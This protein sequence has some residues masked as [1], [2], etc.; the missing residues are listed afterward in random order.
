MDE[1][2][3]TTAASS[4]E[5]A[6]R[7]E[8]QARRSAQG[9]LWTWTDAIVISCPQ[10][11]PP[12][13]SWPGLSCGA[14]SE[15]ALPRILRRASAYSA[16]RCAKVLVCWEGRDEDAAF[17]AVPLLEGRFRILICGGGAAGRESSWITMAVRIGE[18]L[19]LDFLDLRRKK[20][21]VKEE[22]ISVQIRK[23]KKHSNF[24]VRL[25]CLLIYFQLGF[26]SSL[27]FLRRKAQYIVHHQYCLQSCESA[28]HADRWSQTRTESV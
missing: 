20:K 23:K 26:K 5:R 13:L 8:R 3:L 22:N 11:V 14:S 2:L 25:L 1:L 7:Q 10:K 17:P 15:E 28:H 16:S 4:S 19:A 6:C 27:D 9:N 12:Y 18:P 24:S 21:G